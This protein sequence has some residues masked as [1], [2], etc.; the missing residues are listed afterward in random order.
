MNRKK[1]GC[2]TTIILFFAVSWTASCTVGGRFSVGR[3]DPDKR[4]DCWIAGGSCANDDADYLYFSGEGIG[5]KWKSAAMSRR[6][7]KKA[8]TVTALAS[9]SSYLN[10]EIRNV[11]EESAVCTGSREEGLKCKAQIVSQTTSETKSRVYAGDYEIDDE[12]YDTPDKI[13]NVRIRVP[14]SIAR[15]CLDN[16]KTLLAEY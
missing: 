3:A 6:N 2:L 15:S 16:A 14:N 9:F 4:P 11:I 1:A 7:A 5:R 8:A 12:Y 10:D 13:Y